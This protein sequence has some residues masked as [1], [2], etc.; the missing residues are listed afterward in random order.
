MPRSP[1]GQICTK[2]ATTVGVD[3]LI[4]SNKFFG[5]RSRGVDSVGG[6]KL[7]PLTDKACRS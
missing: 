4:T 5:D 3:D 1:R 2:F 6:Q 7:S